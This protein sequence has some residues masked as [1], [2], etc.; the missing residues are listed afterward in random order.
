MAGCGDSFVGLARCLVYPISGSS[1]GYRPLNMWFTYT[2]D[3][4][5]CCSNYICFRSSLCLRPANGSCISLVRHGEFGRLIGSGKRRFVLGFDYLPRL[6]HVQASTFVS[7]PR[8]EPDPGEREQQFIHSA[9]WVPS[10]VKINIFHI[11]SSMFPK[12]LHDFILL[13]T[14]QTHVEV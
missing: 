3:L 4:F 14:L 1:S 10:I 11:P 13:G 5:V 2:Y 8:Q 6:P 7:E 12:F 9:A